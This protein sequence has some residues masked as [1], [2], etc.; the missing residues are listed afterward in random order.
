MIQ[1]MDDNPYKSPETAGDLPHD[2]VNRLRFEAC[3]CLLALMASI[4][5]M[6]FI[7]GLAFGDFSLTAS[8][9][10][11]ALIGGVIYTWLPWQDRTGGDQ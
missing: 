10:I 11:V 6:A 1:A 4:C 2:A 3:G 8:L 5:A 9:I 7:A